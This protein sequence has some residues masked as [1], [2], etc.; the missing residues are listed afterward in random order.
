MTSATVRLTV[1]I[2]DVIEAI[3]EQVIEPGDTE[4]FSISEVARR[5]ST[6]PRTIESVIAS[7]ELR[8][9]K[10]GRRRLVRRTSLERWLK[11]KAVDR[12]E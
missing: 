10:V 4:A 7:G 1:D 2:G 3:R 9:F 5:T 12:D 8:S 11:E 6:S